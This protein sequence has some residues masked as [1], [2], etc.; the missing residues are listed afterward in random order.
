MEIGLPERFSQVAVEL[1]LF[2]SGLQEGTVSAP[3]QQNPTNSTRPQSN[4]LQLQT[5]SLDGRTISLK[6]NMVQNETDGSI[7]NS[8][9]LRFSSCCHCYADNLLPKHQLQ[10]I[11]CI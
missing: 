4:L 7:T 8:I 3:I 5:T 6:T 1:R 2:Q 10:E 9:S 11:S